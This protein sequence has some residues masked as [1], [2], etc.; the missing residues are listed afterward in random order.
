MK[1][2]KLLA[3]LA[4]SLTSLNLLGQSTTYKT[5]NKT[6]KLSPVKVGATISFASGNQLTV[7]GIVQG[8]LANKIFYSAEYRKGLMRG[9]SNAGIADESELMTTQNETKGMYMELGAEYALSDKKDEGKM[10]IVTHTDMT[11]EHY[12]M[13]DCDVRKLVTVGGGVFSISH[14]YYMDRDTAHYFTSGS[15]K[16][17]PDKD[18]I[19]HSNINTTG[20]FAGISLRKIKK[21]AVSS[22]GYRYRKV[23]ATSWAFQG[24]F[25]SSK[26][27]DLVI[28]GN[29]YAIDNAKSAPIGYRIMWRA[30]RGPTSTTVELGKMPHIAFDN[31]NNPD[32]SMFGPQGISTFV[33]YFRVGFNFI[34]YGNE[35][36]YGL[37]QKKEH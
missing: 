37:R 11:S 31:D 12:F 8:C 32:M 30:E 1:T 29:T 36:K 22:G 28:A 4:L 6:E 23:K 35:R 25:G 3:A 26:M 13:A 15:T 27:Q 17:Q 9:F 19:F 10:K 24:M 5:D 21:A 34:L 2:T 18:R 33:N 7:G 14:A 16:L 20:L